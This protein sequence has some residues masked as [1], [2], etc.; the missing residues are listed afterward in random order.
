MFFAHFVLRPSAEFLPL[1][2]R[3]N[4]WAGVL[5]RFMRMVWIVV[6]VLPLSGYWMLFSYYGGLD[7]LGLHLYV[8][9]VVGWLM[10]LLFFYVYFIPFKQ[11]KIR[12]REE[13][14]PEAGMFMLQIRRIVG[15]NL[16]LGVLTVIS[17]VGGRFLF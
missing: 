1:P 10:I 7:G 8:M 14:Y 11:L 3:I 2:E 15:F 6:V 13:L 4:L 5:G 17:A 12:L 16:L 9:Q